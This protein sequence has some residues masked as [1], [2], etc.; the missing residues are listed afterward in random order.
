MLGKY[1]TTIL[2]V[3]LLLI[4]VSSL[5]ALDNDAI[6]REITQEGF[7]LPAMSRSAECIAYNHWGFDLDTMIIPSAG[8]GL[9]EIATRFTTGDPNDVLD[10]IW[11]KINN[12]PSNPGGDDTFFVSVYADD[13]GLPGAVLWSAVLEPGT[14]ADSNGN[15]RIHPD[16]IVLPDEFHVGIA[17]AAS[18]NG[19]MFLADSGQAGTGR[20]SSRIGSTWYSTE[21]ALGQ[22]QHLLMTARLCSSPSDSC[23]ADGNADGDAGGIVNIADIT[24]LIEYI[25]LGIPYAP[26]LNRMDLNGDCRIDSLDLNVLID[27]VFLIVWLDLPVL[28]CCPG[29]VGGMDFPNPLG[30]ATV[31]SD[32]NS[33]TISNIGSSGE[34]GALIELG[35]DPL[36]IQTNIEHVDLSVENAGIQFQVTGEIVGPESGEKTPALVCLVGA[37]TVGGAVQI[38]AD[39]NPIGA[40][41]VKVEAYDA[42]GTYRGGA[43]VP[44]GGNVAIGTDN[45]SGLPSLVSLT[46]KAGAPVTFRLLFDR[47]ILLNLTG[48]LQIVGQEIRLVAPPGLTQAV[49]SLQGFQVTGQFLGYIVMSGWQSVFC[50][51][52]FT[53]NVNFDI[54]DLTDI[55]DLTK[56]V[57]HLFVTYEE[58]ACYE[59]ANINGDLGGNIDISDLT[60]LV[61]FLFVTF[62]LPADCLAGP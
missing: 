44:G 24:A 29:Q 4:A 14:Y 13:A 57:N 61:N 42:A 53:G 40:T 30:Q 34:D 56:L 8:T 15:V 12:V 50:C 47:P 18:G 49:V 16:P 27:Y 28:T 3:F 17:V 22:D 59:E 32:S 2:T 55:S 20:S 45:G 1:L 9:V 54:V 46:M 21:D 51:R 23:W 43:T 25:E 38:F 6:V 10:S 26:P 11:T 39:Y 35:Q 7:E 48:G 52:G 62:E 37:T 36:M 19:E 5:V 31:E 33:I 60:K 41:H 58:L